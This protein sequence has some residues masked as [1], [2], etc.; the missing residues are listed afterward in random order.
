MF[1]KKEVVYGLLILLLLAVVFFLK[2]LPPHTDPGVDILEPGVA[3]VHNGE[4]LVLWFPAGKGSAKYF[5]HFENNTVTV[6]GT[7][8]TYY[9]TVL[10]GCETFRFQLFYKVEACRDGQDMIFRWNEFFLGVR[11]D[12]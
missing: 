8:L 4:T 11:I 9:R 10:E 7:L 1:K 3:R 5:F 12:R 2:S 6:K